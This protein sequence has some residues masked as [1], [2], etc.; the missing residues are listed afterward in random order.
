MNK[1][2]LESTIYNLFKPIKQRIRI[3]KQGG[4]NTALFPRRSLKYPAPNPPKNIPIDHRIE[5]GALKL[6]NP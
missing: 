1:K 3:I 6:A 2:E 4:I 5:T